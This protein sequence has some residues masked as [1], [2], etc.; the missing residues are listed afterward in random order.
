MAPEN[1]SE[2]RARD[3]H[4]RIDREVDKIGERIKNAEDKIDRVL[5]AIVTTSLGFAVAAILYVVQLKG[6]QP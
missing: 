5:L 3:L 1:L 6:G 2:T 4:A